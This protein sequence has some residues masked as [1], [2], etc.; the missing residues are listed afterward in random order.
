MKK[1]TCHDALG[2]QYEFNESDYIDRKSVYGVF[3]DKESVLM[4][5]DAASLNWEFPGGGVE[6]GERPGQALTR[7]FRE[8]TGLTMGKKLSTI[9]CYTEYYLDLVSSNP[10]R[11]NRCFYTVTVKGGN[12][13][14]NGN[15]NDTVAARYIPTSEL[16]NMNLRETV[17]KVLYAVGALR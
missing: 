4:V 2:K 12:L 5:Q 15:S 16:K 9:S 17:T 1:I 13:L 7:E 8:K 11:S 6:A 10:W 14:P 3:M